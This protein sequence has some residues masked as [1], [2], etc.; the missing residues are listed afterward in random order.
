MVFGGHSQELPVTEL[1]GCL[2]KKKSFCFS[3]AE[4]RQSQVILQHLLQQRRI[5]AAA[6]YCVL[7]DLAPGTAVNTQMA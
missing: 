6:P 4:Q 5:R 1:L 2:G 7:G 3:C